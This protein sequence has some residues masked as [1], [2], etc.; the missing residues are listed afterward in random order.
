MDNV[1]VEGVTDDTLECLEA[2]F[3]KG[4]PSPLTASVKLIDSPLRGSAH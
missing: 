1:L 2:L 3:L 4:P